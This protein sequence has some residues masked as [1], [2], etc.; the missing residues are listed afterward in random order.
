MT[1]QPAATS[2]A[3]T[4]LAQAPDPVEEAR[5]YVARQALR[6]DSRGRVGLELEFHLVDL[7]L[8]ARR[9][10]WDEVTRLVASAPGLPQCSAVTVEPGGQV[11]LSTPPLPT[12]VDAVAGLTA[13][14]DA[15]RRHA[16]EHGFG[17]A[18][19][20]AD[21]ARKPVRCNPAPRYRAMERHFAAVGCARP[22]RAMMSGTAALQVNLDAGEPEDWSDR[23]A[24]LRSLVPVLVAV[25]SCSP[26]LGGRSSGW[27][28]M[29]QETWAG[30]DP[31][32]S[33]PV[34]AGDPAAAWA[35]YAL[36]A[37]VMLVE[38]DG[39]LVGT[40]RRF[41]FA[42]W[43]AEPSLGGREA[44]WADLDRHLTTLFPPVRPRGYLE[45][46]CIDAMPDPWWPALAALVVTLVDEPRAADA[47]R[48]AA[49]P[50][51]GRW[52][53]AARDGMADPV[54]RR[55]SRD[56]LALAVAHAPDAVRPGLERLAGL[57]E[58][59]RT[60]AD[61]VRARIERHGP[62]AVLEEEARA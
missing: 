31:G 20:G 29:R 3:T 53:Q 14:R 16:A 11:E 56:C 55:S 36:E 60:P 48:D 50:A 28:S 2:L 19:L 26:Y 33:G 15:L 46:R 44:G 24:L 42:D 10:G 7:A 18:P 9:P 27:H 37:T 1:A 49:A 58:Q 30:I 17:L 4:P 5:A 39:E 43:L 6:P 59:G 47:A 54:V 45:I 34:P 12:L 25:S 35:S 21:P 41:S 23:V 13:D 38:H 32:R 51:T 62:L 40:T 57:V 61:E 8:P 22:G 52:E